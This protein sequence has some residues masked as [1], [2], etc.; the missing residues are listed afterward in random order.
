M[1][2]IGQLC[3]DEVNGVWNK[4][5]AWPLMLSAGQQLKALP[6]LDGKLDWLAVDLAAKAVLEVADTMNANEEREVA[7]VYHILNPDRTRT[8]SDL[9]QWTQ[10]IDPSL[11]TLSPKDWIARLEALRGGHPAKKLIGLWK[12]AYGQDEV[13]RRETENEKG[14]EE[15][16]KK[17]VVFEIENAKVSSRTMREVEPV[18]AEGFARMWKWIGGN[19]GVEVGLEGGGKDEGGEKVEKEEKV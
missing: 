18:N 4:S 9:L 10:K 13:E 11:T 8:W 19:V 2:R 17:E 6:R 3:G 1:L 5:E 15:G 7:P 14:N 16:V 12:E